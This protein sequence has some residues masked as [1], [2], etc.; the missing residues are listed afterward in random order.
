M[1]GAGTLE[2]TAGF[3]AIRGAGPT[4]QVGR[5]CCRSARIAA[6]GCIPCESEVQTPYGR[7][8]FEDGVQ[9]WRSPRL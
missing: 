7:V 2:A 1:L 4:G 5:A 9:A 3:E 8:E 6:T